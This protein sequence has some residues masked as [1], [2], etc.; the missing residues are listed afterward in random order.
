[1]IEQTT[2]FDKRYQLDASEHVEFLQEQAVELLQFG[3]RFVWPSGGASY[4]DEQGNPQY[5]EGL[6]AYETGRYAHV[7]ALGSILD[8][9]SRDASL[10]LSQQALQGFTGQ[11]LDRQNGGWYTRVSQE[12]I[13]DS[14]KSCYAHAFVILGASSASMVGVNGADEL[15]EHALNV[16]AKYFWDDEEGMPYDTWDTSWSMPD[17]YRGINASMHS[18]EALLAAADA[19]Q[20][21]TYRQWAGRIIQRVIVFAQQFDLMIP[22]H[23][24]EHW[25][26][27]QEYNSDH[28]DDQFKPYG[29]TPGHS[30]E[31]ARLICQWACASIKHQE[32]T[33]HEYEFAI[34]SAQQLFK[35]AVRNAWHADGN[36]GLVYT[37]D[38]QGQPVVH[39]RMHWTLA[40][41]INTAAYLARLSS[42]EK[43]GEFRNWYARFWQ[44]VDMYMIDHQWGSWF[45]QLDKNNS[46]IGTV[47]PGKPD[48]YH[49]LQATLIPQITDTNLLGLS[50]VPALKQFRG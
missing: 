2:Q 30:L 10:T 4:L 37:V 21:D 9:P 22:E 40:E 23:F 17:S 49:A 33:T 6:Y 31:W 41:G 24:N 28:K 42:S 45:H 18:V 19:L 38:W 43:S 27:I 34:A 36:D 50:I 26:P 11:L 39:D 46:V 20:T 13:A 3:R 16:Y 12:G 48:V 44:Y 1:M 7:Y 32:I 8:I 25:E 35:T 5:Q 14:G 15:L 29:T 47:W